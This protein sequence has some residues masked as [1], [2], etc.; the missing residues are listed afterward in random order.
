M[1]EGDEDKK[2]IERYRAKRDFKRTPEPAPG[3]AEERGPRA[4]F[5]VHRHDA[6]RL[7]YDLRLELSLIHI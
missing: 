7:H 5:V 2:S 3:P 1:A 4:V 6:T